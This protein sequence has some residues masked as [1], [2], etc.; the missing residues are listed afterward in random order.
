MVWRTSVTDPS[1]PPFV[2]PEY[3]EARYQR[4]D[5]RKVSEIAQERPEAVALGL[6]LEKLEQPAASKRQG[7]RTDLEHSGNLPE[8]SRGDT[9]DKVGPAVGMS[10]RNYFGPS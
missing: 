6:D 1:H 4:H 9:R 10:G 7:T 8:S 5:R 2:G 3:S